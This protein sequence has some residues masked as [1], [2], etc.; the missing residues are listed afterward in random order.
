MMVGKVV[1]NQC[2]MDN[3]ERT[4]HKARGEVAFI[5]KFIREFVKPTTELVANA[6]NGTPMVVHSFDMLMDIEEGV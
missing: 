1:A 6:K 5:G 3:P 2:S 4:D